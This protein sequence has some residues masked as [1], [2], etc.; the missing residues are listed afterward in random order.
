MIEVKNLNKTYDRARPGDNRVL[1]DISFT[2]PETG[3]VC[4]LGPSGCGKT[5]LLNAIGGLDRF[6]SGKLST[7]DTCVS[8]YGTAAYEA[9]RNRNFGYIFQNYYLLENHSVAYNVYLGLHSL[10]LTHKEKLRRVRMALHA[11]D[12]DRFIRRKVSELSGG[13]QQRIAIARALARRPRVI[14][15]DEPTGNLDEANTRN[16]CTLLRQ[17]SRESLVIMVTHEERIA[18]FFADRII[19][20]DQ[21]TIAS[22]SESWERSDLYLAT[23]KEVY[24][25]DF[26]DSTVQQ[27][28]LTLRLLRTSDAP[29]VSLTV[30]AA[31]DQIILKLSDNRAVMLSTDSELP[32]IMEGPRPVLTL[33]AVDQGPDSQSQLF[34][35]PP[36]PQCRAGKG[37]S[38][39]MLT[40]EALHL[41]RGKGLRRV[42]MRI[43]LVLLTVLTLLTVSDFIT[44]SK[45]DP[46]D[47][48]TTD[49]HVLTVK[50]T[51]GSETPDGD[52]PAGYYT[53][54]DYHAA[55]YVDHI[56][57][58]AGDYDFLPIQASHP[59]Y[60]IALFFQMGNAAQKMPAFS[61]V[62][63]DRLDPGTLLC[64]KM[65]ETS[66]QIVI[67]RILLDAILQKDGIIQN[68]VQDY[69]TF[70]GEVLDYGAKGLNPVI[71]GVS[72]S[73]ER[74]I[75]AR[76][77]TLYTLGIRGTSLITLSELQSRFPGQY[78]SL[79]MD[80]DMGGQ[81]PPI[82]FRPSD[83]TD[84]DCIVNHA[85]AGVIWTYRLG[86]SYGAFPND[87]IVR[88][89]FANKELSAQIVVTDSALEQMIKNN[90]SDE[91]QI[92][93]ADKAAMIEYLSQPTEMEQQ[94]YLQVQLRDTYAEKYAQYQQAATIRA[95]A[96]TIVTA[97][98]L[99]LSMVMLYLLCRTQVNQRLGLVAVYRL[100]GIPGRKL[101]AI[102][103][104]EGTLSALA[105]IVP[106]T[107]LT[108]LAITLAAKVPELESTL[109]L[110]WQAT[111]LSA[112]GIL[113]YYL[114][115]ALLP[116]TRLLRLPPAQLAAK[117]DM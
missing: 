80:M 52:P 63:I 112:A 36:A 40:R 64:G 12:M 47:F 23:D 108:W 93:C 31:K 77:S 71:V 62:P 88:G 49:S 67:D 19:R 73:G 9:Q 30:V 111:C 48:I 57:K 110:P 18:N 115:V 86:Q 21:G 114:L 17:A 11:V 34:R 38:G 42:G 16:I 87:K 53:W 8:R 54:I 27:D 99:V 60:T 95:D 78:D 25:G 79:E 46:Q 41:M 44:I 59:K 26:Q 28:Q 66:E 6:D 22:D 103:L 5:S 85:Q 56:S 91:I 55:Q 107:G 13:Q 100:L 51:A 81:L 35:E 94:D 69:S 89:Y 106:A 104:L 116:L 50:L 84:N 96:R 74:S 113:V 102:F 117:Y 65:P 39:A 92:W 33:E 37:L 109:E 29:S 98:V 101:H 82:T 97:T 70:L 72:D 61:A 2:L 83:M 14:F 1:K 10:D 105:T 32:K 20:L 24:T 45:V 15:A 7:G 3:F 90:Y 58:A 68:S 43:F 76:Q 75:Y 4:I